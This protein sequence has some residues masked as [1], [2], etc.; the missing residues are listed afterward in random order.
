M[1]T[2]PSQGC[3]SALFL[4]PVRSLLLAVFLLPAWLAVTPAHAT[5]Y[6]GRVVGISDGDT[7]TLL[8]AEK[9]QIKVR[10]GE[11]DTPE[12]RQPYGTRAKQ[13][14]SDLAFG[15]EARVVEQDEDRYGRG[16]ADACCQRVLLFSSPVWPQARTGRVSAV[17]TLS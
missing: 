14:L 3:Q 9:Q 15:K 2:K 13:A 12:S 1:P 4:R 16:M 5:E 6:A 10:L 11:I 8:T 7:L 17:T